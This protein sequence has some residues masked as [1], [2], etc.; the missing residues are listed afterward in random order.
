[1]GN[2]S[3]NRKLFVSCGLLLAFVMATGTVAWISSATMNARQ[4]DAFQVAQRVQ[5]LDDIQQVNSQIFSA[6]KT[7]IL[8]GVAGDKKL[9]QVWTDR[10]Q[11]SIEDGIKKSDELVKISTGQ[12]KDD[13]IKLKKAMEV[14]STRCD[15]CHAVAIGVD[16]RKE[17]DK[18]LQVSNDSETVANNNEA[19]ASAMG[20]T[21]QAAFA[22]GVVVARSAYNETRTIV[23][24]VMVPA[25][26][27]GIVAALVVMRVS[28]KLQ[29]VASQLR[30][31]AEAVMG[32]S[33]QVS[34]AAQS[35]SEGATEQA[36]ALEETSAA[37]EEMA[38]TTATNAEQSR[39][40]AQMTADVDKQVQA[41]ERAL[42]T[43]VASI[44][45]IKQSS[46]Q[47]SKI[48]KTIDEIAFQTNLLAL[49]AAV[50]AARAGEAGM[51]FAVVADEVRNLAQRSAQA[52]K[53][54]AELIEESIQ[55]TETGARNVDQVVETVAGIR[56]TVRQV[57]SIADQVSD[58]SGQQAQGVSQVATAISQM[59]SVTQRTA[60]TAEENAAAAVELTSQAE[61]TMDV[62][63]DLEATV[64][65]GHAGRQRAH[66]S[67]AG[68]DHASSSRGALP[69]AA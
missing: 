41:S 17:I 10:L 61:S 46:Q 55:R 18:V 22:D 32:A 37:M 6:E 26:L 53:D 67:G 39:Q 28:R 48:I 20:R 7:M 60:A 15:A 52:A 4:T 16:L 31:G 19:I 59:E 63:T 13:A 51:G 57:K 40:A 30:A 27:V 38:S 62:V 42:E 23:G 12:T 11:K 47:V 44:S 14:W 49:N 29:D 50:E 2:W 3:L 36:A 64:N 34:S 68:E 35:L 43:M 1:V 54:T 9:L 66:S 69:R 65:G 5:L 58:S 21:E 56:E 45:S 33:S 25:L 8:A 24:S